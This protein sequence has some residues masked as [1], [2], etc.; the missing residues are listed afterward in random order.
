MNNN[1]CCPAPSHI[2]CWF[3]PASLSSYTYFDGVTHPPPL[4]SHLHHSGSLHRFVMF[5]FHLTLFWN[6]F[7][8]L[9]DLSFSV[10]SIKLPS[11]AATETHLRSTTSRTGQPLTPH[12]F[13][14]PYTQLNTTNIVLRLNE[15][16][17]RMFFCRLSFQ[18]T[19]LF[20]DLLLYSSCTKIMLISFILISLFLTE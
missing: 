2:C 1:G 11:C 8:C 20:H 9:F 5:A 12:F 4:F 6:H 7:H 10:A 19:A 18:I 16:L 13:T 14:Q 3:W 17:V 15:P